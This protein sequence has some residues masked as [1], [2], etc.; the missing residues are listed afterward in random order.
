MFRENAKLFGKTLRFVPHFY[1]FSMPADYNDLCSDGT[2]Q[3]CAED[4]VAL[5][6]LGTKKALIGMVFPKFQN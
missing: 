2:A 5:I 4:P 1:V 3:F 6:A